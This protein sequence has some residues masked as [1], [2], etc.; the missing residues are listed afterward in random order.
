VAEISQPSGIDGRASA[1]H[2]DTMDAMAFAAR[3]RSWLG[4]VP[5]AGGRGRG[6]ANPASSE[7]VDV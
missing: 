4:R 6:S 5:L 3:A 2:A 7:A 1:D